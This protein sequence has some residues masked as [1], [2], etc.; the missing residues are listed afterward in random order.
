MGAAVAGSLVVMLV[1]SM[2]LKAQSS[3]AQ[4][5]GLI[6]DP[7]GAVRSGYVPPPVLIA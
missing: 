6:S 5:S 3:N 4:I 7:S 2:Q 1:G